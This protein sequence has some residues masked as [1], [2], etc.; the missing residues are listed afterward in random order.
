[1]PEATF[2]ASRAPLSVFFDTVQWCTQGSLGDVNSPIR[3]EFW[4]TTYE[5]LRRFGGISEGE[6]ERL[7]QKM[8]KAAKDAYD[9]KILRRT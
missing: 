7:R 6:A 2:F 3:R 9:G 1:M 5:R 8:L 4:P